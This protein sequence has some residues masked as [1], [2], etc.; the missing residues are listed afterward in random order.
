MP[1]AHLTAFFITTF[2]LLAGR[3]PCPV[4][5]AVADFLSPAAAFCSLSCQLFERDVACI[6]CNIDSPIQDGG[7]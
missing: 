7:F 5:K 3:V 2:T 4:C 6:A 1:G